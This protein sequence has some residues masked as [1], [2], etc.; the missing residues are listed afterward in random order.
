MDRRQTP[1]H[2]A[3]AQAP[4]RITLL[5]SDGA[6]DQPIPAQL[7]DWS[8]RG[9]RLL[10]DQALA[11][12]TPVRIDWQDQLVLGEVCHC[13]PATPTGFSIGLRLHQMLNGL[14]RLRQLSRR[15]MGDERP[16]TLQV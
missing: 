12:G 11:P 4:L 15:L 6:G 13:Q 7:I 8:D 3:V 1:R 5:S 16:A 10:T 9:M 14:D 2:R